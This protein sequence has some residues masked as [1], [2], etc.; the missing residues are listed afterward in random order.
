MS[1][2]I[3]G[4]DSSRDVV[5]VDSMETVKTLRLGDDAAAPACSRLDGRQMRS[6]R[7][8]HHYSD[9]IMMNFPIWGA[10]FPFG[11]PRRFWMKPLGANIRYLGKCLIDQMSNDR[12]LGMKLML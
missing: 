11:V 7:V 6:G 12:F 9:E 4:G 3:R 10:S 2:G 1:P 8:L 5:I